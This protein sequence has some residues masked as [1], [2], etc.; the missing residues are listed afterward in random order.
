M[1]QQI[2]VIVF[3]TAGLLLTAIAVIGVLRLPDFYTRLHA[4]GKVESLGVFLTLIGL[5]AYNGFSLVSLKLVMIAIFILLANPIG[6]HILSR[7]ALQSG[8][9]PWQKEEEGRDE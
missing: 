1:A 5:A 2:I 4:S 9:K 7:G 6:T 3:M 8:L